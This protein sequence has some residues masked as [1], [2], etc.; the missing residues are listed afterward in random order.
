VME[1]YPFIERV[2]I[3]EEQIRSKV[4]ELAAQITKDYEGQELFLV[5]ILHGSFIFISDLARAIDNSK[6][7]V[8]V[9]FMS[10][11][12]YGDSDVSS[13]IVK[14]VM[15]TKKSIEEKHVLIVEDIVDSGL[16]LKYLLEM[17]E[18]RRPK[19]LHCAVLLRKSQS[20]F[21]VP[22]KYFGWE[23]DKKDFIVGYGL[24]YSGLYRCLNFVGVLKEEIYSKK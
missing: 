1:A 6:V 10:V 4:K 19:S 2:I 9:D 5:G 24:D 22:L 12:S 14:V 21:V 23:V 8:N 13:G 16:T 15:D 18:N 11:S 20:K 3:T 7:N 17:L